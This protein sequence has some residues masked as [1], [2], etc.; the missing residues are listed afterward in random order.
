MRLTP[1]ENESGLQRLLCE[2]QISQTD[3]PP[4]DDP[5]VQALGADCYRCRVLINLE[6]VEYLDSSGVRWLIASHKR[7]R[8][9]GGRL[10]LHSTPPLV[11]H[12]FKL[13]KMQLVLHIE[14]NEA[15]A[16]AAALRSES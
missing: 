8:E 16:R 4:G 15:A 14:E 2:G 1:Q 7:F 11:D 13:L 3:F 9:C 6:R 12:V 10:V 5:L